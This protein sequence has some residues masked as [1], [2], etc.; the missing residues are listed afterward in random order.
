[1]T[2]SKEI[3]ENRVINLDALNMRHFYRRQDCSKEDAPGERI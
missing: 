1:M 3:G 2:R